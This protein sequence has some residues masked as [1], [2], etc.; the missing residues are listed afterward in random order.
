MGQA[1]YAEPLV[2][3]LRNCKVKTPIGSFKPQEEE[4]YLQITDKVKY[5][6]EVN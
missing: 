4:R 5:F 2:R 3:P 6:L 1:Y